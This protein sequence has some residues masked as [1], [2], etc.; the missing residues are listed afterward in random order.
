[1]V[2][3][4]RHFFK[5]PVP[6]RKIHMLV[7]AVTMMMV[8]K[9]EWLAF[10]STGGCVFRS[11]VGSIIPATYYHSRFTS[12][13]AGH[14]TLSQYPSHFLPPFLMLSLIC[15]LFD[16]LFLSLRHKHTS[17]I[18]PTPIHI[19]GFVSLGLATQIGTRILSYLCTQAYQNSHLSRVNRWCK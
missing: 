2:A 13:N 4:A 11:V 14:A 10:S 7:I 19:L 15:C 9:I 16:T 8:R 12:C 6:L 17:S 5:F 1:M 18:P 3:I